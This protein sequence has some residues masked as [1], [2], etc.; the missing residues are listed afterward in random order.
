MD[1]RRPDTNYLPMTESQRVIAKA[2]SEAELQDFVRNTAAAT[3]WLYYHTYDSRR[4]DPG[5]PDCVM[6]KNGTVIFAELKTEKKKLTDSQERWRLRLEVA[7]DFG[8]VH[9]YLWRPSDMEAIRARL[10]RQS[11]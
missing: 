2:M 9:Y 5:F 8:D 1:T 7:S 6:V 4:S 3:G 11:G 10:L